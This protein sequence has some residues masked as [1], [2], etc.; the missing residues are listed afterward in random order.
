[1]RSTINNEEQA[2]ATYANAWEITSSEGGKLG[3]IEDWNAQKDRILTKPKVAKALRLL[4]V[5]RM[6]IGGRN[7]VRGTPDNSVVTRCPWRPC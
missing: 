7:K 2:N 3:F 5:E 1:M 6:D 4:P